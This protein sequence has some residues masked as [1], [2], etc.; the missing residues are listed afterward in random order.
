[1]I[2]AED[3]LGRAPS[4]ATLRVARMLVDHAL[5]RGFDRA[6]GQLFE[7]GSAYGA[8]VDRSVQWWAQFEAWNALFLLDDVAGPSPGPYWDAGV[9]AWHL[10]RTAFADAQQPGVCPQM[11]ADGSVRCDAKSHQWF[12]SYHTAR[13][14]LLSSDRLRGSGGAR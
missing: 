4:R 10:T 13:A 5:A 2:E 6:R 8:P 9:R 7:S 1:M 3:A 14:L 12:A 11:E